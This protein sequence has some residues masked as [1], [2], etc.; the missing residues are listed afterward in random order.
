MEPTTGP[1]RPSCNSSQEQGG[2]VTGDAMSPPRSRR[3]S[4]H[5]KGTEISGSRAPSRSGPGSCERKTMPPEFA[6]HTA[7]VSKIHGTRTIIE[8]ITLSFYYGAKIGILGHNGSGKSTLLNIIAGEDRDFDGEVVVTQG[9]T[10]GLVPQEPRLDPDRT[11]R[12]HLEDAVAPSRAL[13]DEYN[14]ITEKLGDLEDPDEMEKAMER[15]T[16]LQDRIDAQDLWD[17]DQRLDRASDALLLPPGDADVTKLSG[18]EKRRVVLCMVLLKQPDILLLDEPTNHLDAES[19]AW[20]EGHLARYPGTVLAVTHDRY[21]LDN[22]AQ[23]ILELDR[24]RGIPFKGN[25]TG[26]LEQKQARLE[27]ENRQ[28]SARQRVLARELEWVHA[29]PKARQAKGKARLARYEELAARSAEARKDGI[30]LRLPPGPKLGNRVLEAKGVVKGFD[31]RTLMEGLDFDLPPGGIVG[32]IGPNGVGKTTLFRLIV[33]EERPDAGEIRLGES[34]SLSY[35]DQSREA[36]DP[37][38]D[39]WE[40]ISGGEEILE[41]GPWKMN[42]RAYVSRFNFKGQ[43]QSKSIEA[44]SGGE[45]NRV[46]LAKLLKS[47]GNLLLLDEPTNDLDVETLQVLE[48]ALLDFPGCAVVSTHD[49]MFL[50]RIATHILAFEGE[51]KVRWFEGNFAA[52]A[53]RRREELGED[54]FENRRA[55]YRK[56][57]K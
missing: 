20:L 50:D 17:L 55:R 52:Y 37:K 48:Q 15:M 44:L 26:W 39:I 46:H 54:P 53:E 27:M 31:G 56:L 14:A 22:V 4:A 36:L 9:L 7:G 6:F 24:G 11:V 51:G 32:V 5:P 47:G 33:G 10:V 34:V 43:E 18:G 1:I 49:R 35:V 30:D 40:E 41:V 3:T 2:I 29:S 25:Y 8:G 21:F 23:W 38:K 42:S 45:R 28:E 12:E 16:A 57:Q 13:V 19:V